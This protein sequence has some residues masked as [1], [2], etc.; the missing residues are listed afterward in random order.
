MPINDECA[1]NDVRSAAGSFPKRITHNNNRNVGVRPAFF[2]GIKAALSWLNAH[3]GEEVFRS[4]KSE[5]PPHSLV[6]ANSGE[7]KIDRGCVSE[8]LLAR[9]QGFVFG[10]RELPVVVFGIL[11]G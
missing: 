7:G 10:V 9:T 3:Q 2:C 8:D 4:Q 11:S 6:T 5:T 1:A